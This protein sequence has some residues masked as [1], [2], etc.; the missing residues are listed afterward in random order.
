MGVEMRINPCGCIRL[1]YDRLYLKY[2]DLIP[3]EMIY[4]QKVIFNTTDYI[5]NKIFEQKDDEFLSYFN[6]TFVQQNSPQ[7]VPFRGS[8][9]FDNLGF[10]YTNEEQFTTAEIIMNYG[11]KQLVFKIGNPP[12]T[13]LEVPFT[14]SYANGISEFSHQ[15]LFN[16]QEVQVRVGNIDSEPIVSTGHSYISVD[17]LLAI[18]GKIDFP[19]DLYDTYVYVT[20]TQKPA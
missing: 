16:M 17:P 11:L 5:I 8:F 4:V 12:A 3:E 1:I 15:A 20:L 6:I 18:N 7:G 14:A 13:T 2:G 10:Y 9:A 19:Y